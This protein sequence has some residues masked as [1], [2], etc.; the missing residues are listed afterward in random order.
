MSALR[1]R[2]LFATF[3]VLQ[4]FVLCGLAV[5]ARAGARPSALT[6][7]LAFSFLPYAG[8][9]FSARGASDAMPT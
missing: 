6:L 1:D 2:A 8:A 7:G 5:A 9:L 3:A 4:C